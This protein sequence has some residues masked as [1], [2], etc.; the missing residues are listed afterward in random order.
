MFSVD[1]TQITHSYFYNVSIKATLTSSLGTVYKIDYFTIYLDWCDKTVVY[2]D[3]IDNRIYTVND[4]INS[5]TISEF[6]ESFGIC[7]TLSYVSTLSDY[8]DLPALITFDPSTR[9][10]TVDPN[11]IAASTIYTIYVSAFLSYGAYGT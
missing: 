4:P 10:F 7:G 2:G 5:F 9:T 11:Q 6:T 1:T 8:S 3:M